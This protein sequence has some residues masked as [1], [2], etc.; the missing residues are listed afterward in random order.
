MT[1]ADFV[2]GRFGSPTLAL[3]IAVTGVVATMPYIAL[4]LLGIQAVLNVIGIGGHWP[5]IAAFA[6]LAA[7]T[8]RSGL[9]APALIAFVKDALVYVLII[10]AII[11]IP[12]Q[13]RRLDAHLHRRQRPLQGHRAAHRRPAH[14]RQPAPVRD[15]GVWLGRCHLPVPARHHRAARHQEP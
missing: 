5:L 12:A 7:F 3:A 10:V 8:Y 15:A 11:Y 9:R 14:R 13:N 1:P 2:R 6:V 4:N